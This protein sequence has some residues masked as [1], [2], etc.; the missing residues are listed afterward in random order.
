MKNFNISALNRDLQDQL[1]HKIDFKT[2][3][4]GSLGVLES[5]A[6]QIGLHQQSLEPKL[7]QP[8]I[9]VFAGD[10]GIALR[11]LVNP[12]P[13]EVTFQMVMNF[14]QGQAA[15]NV[16]ANQHGIEL[17][18][19]DAGVNYDFQEVPGLIH[20]KIAMGTQDY[21][22]QAAMTSAQLDQ[23]IQAGADLVEDIHQ[24]GTNIIGFGEMGISNTSSAA[25][26]MS[27]ICGLELGECVGAGT[28]LQGEAIELKIKTLQEALDFHSLGQVDALE[29]LRTFGGFEIAQMVGAILAA[30]EHQMSILIDGFICTS[31]L[32]IAHQIHPEVL[33]YCIFTHQSDEQGH[34][35]M[36]QHLQAKALLQVGMRLGEGSGAAVAYP[37]VE[38]ACLFLNEMA[39][40]ESA[41]V[42]QKA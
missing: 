37:L 24:Q 27:Q 7:S 11:N 31:A 16:F 2:K 18:V 19:V 17:L 22:K 30:A 29:V 34:Q 39:S 38:S 26:I 23:S 40:F 10:H 42:S 9:I 15:I 4:Q 35:K 33:D 13:Q 5:L 20:K 32:L 12:F 36:L 25:L 3:P 1:Q 41:Q 8:K 14:L 21:L 28:G 6:L